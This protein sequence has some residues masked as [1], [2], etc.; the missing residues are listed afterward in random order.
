VDVEAV[1]T[2]DTTDEEEQQGWAPLGGE[3]ITEPA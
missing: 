2:P 3:K 1:Q